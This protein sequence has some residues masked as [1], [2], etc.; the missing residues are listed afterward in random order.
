MAERIHGLDVARAFAIYGMVAVNVPLA[1]GLYEHGLTG[2]LAQLFSGRAA[3]IFVVLAGMGLS[4]LGARDPDTARGPILRR[5][6]VLAV[7]GFGWLPLWTADILHYYAFYLSLGAL[8]LRWSDRSLL[9]ASAGLT[10]A[11]PTLFVL[12]D[13]EAHWNW[14]TLHYSGL[15]TPTGLV[16]HVLFDGLHPLVPWQ[17]FLFFGMWLGR[18][19]LRAPAVRRHLLGIL[20][21]VFLS[22]AG[23]SALLV[24]GA[25]TLGLDAPSAHAVFGMTPM[26]PFPTY[27]LGSGSL[28]GLVVLL[29][30]GLAERVPLRPIRHAGQLALTLYVAHVLLLIAP[31]LGLQA[32]GLP[33]RDVLLP[34][35]G[36]W[37]AGATA[38][39]HAW[40]RRHARGPLEHLLRRL[41]ATR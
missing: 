16:R 35:L 6:A 24:R 21:G 33:L 39:A 5:A 40:R 10:V 23:L 11:F 12:F 37:L 18:Q 13:Y 14:E 1:L 26:P 31:L 34:L 27:I 17:A 29:T 41:S 3:A 30:I 20:L 8:A 25:T 4:L 19:D 2:V 28:A 15:F 32:L 9:A 36:I 7:L 38:A 22:T